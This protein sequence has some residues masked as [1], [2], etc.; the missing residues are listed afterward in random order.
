MSLDSEDIRN[1]AEPSQGQVDERVNG[2][3]PERQDKAPAGRNGC[4]FCS[5]SYREKKAL[6]RHIRINHLDEWEKMENEKKE[7]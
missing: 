1:S 5:R 4:S 2:A 3:E 6:N 7:A